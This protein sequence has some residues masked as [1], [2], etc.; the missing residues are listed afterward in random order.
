[1]GKVL[2]HI[3]EFLIGVGSVIHGDVLST[4]R[5]A[6]RV[7]AESS[8]FLVVVPAS[9][10]KALDFSTSDSASNMEALDPV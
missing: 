9:D 4:K 6:F 8:L 7:Y 5:Y 10:F 2:I 3:F 1:M